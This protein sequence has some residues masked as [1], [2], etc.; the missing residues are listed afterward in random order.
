VGNRAILL[1]LLRLCERSHGIV[2][3]SVALG[4]V[5]DQDDAGAFR[6]SSKAGA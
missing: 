5:S 1:A 2:A 4:S 6:E 3:D